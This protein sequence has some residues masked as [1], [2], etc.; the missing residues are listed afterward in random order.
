[1]TALVLTVPLATRQDGKLTERVHCQR[2]FAPVVTRH[3]LIGDFYIDVKQR[4]ILTAAGCGIETT[5]AAVIIMVNHDLLV[6]THHNNLQIGS[7]LLSLLSE[8]VQT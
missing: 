1:M 4:Y 7:K 5:S 2:V 3:Y 6:H 8:T